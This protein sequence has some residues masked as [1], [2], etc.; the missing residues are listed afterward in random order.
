MLL[1][2]ENAGHLNSALNALINDF[3]CWRVG[4]CPPFFI[5]DFMNIEI[6]NEMIEELEE[7]D[8]TYANVADLASLYTVKDKLPMDKVT[9]ELNDV[10]PA[11]TTYKTIKRDYQLNNTDKSKVIRQM[12]FVCEELNE[13]VCM[14]YSNSDL[15]EERQMIMSM[16]KNLNCKY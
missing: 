13:F 9:K 4:N 5:G 8:T 10:F 14:L 11:Y 15:E 16:L 2:K 3:C 6:I 1:P 7:S 12:E